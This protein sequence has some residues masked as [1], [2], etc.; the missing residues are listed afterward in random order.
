MATSRTNANVN[1]NT[2]AAESA[3]REVAAGAGGGDVILLPEPRFTLR[4]VGASLGHSN[5]W[6]LFRCR[7]LG[8]NTSAGLTRGDVERLAESKGDRRPVMLAS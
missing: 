7:K 3:G 1:T 4:E 5:V 8:I 6:V 2:N